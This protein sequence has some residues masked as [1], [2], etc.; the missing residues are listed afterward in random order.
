MFDKSEIDYNTTNDLAKQIAYKRDLYSYDLDPSVSQDNH[1]DEWLKLIYQDRNPNIFPVNYRYVIFLTSSMRD[2][3]IW[4]QY[5]TEKLYGEIQERGVLTELPL[6]AVAV[7]NI[8]AKDLYSP[9][10]NAENTANRLL[11]DRTLTR[12]PE[13]FYLPNSVITNRI[14]ELGFTC[15]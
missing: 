14:L 15:V 2:G 4:E 13:D 1:P 8:L 11:T 6:N 3:K 7:L 5:F 10:F 12:N 9:S